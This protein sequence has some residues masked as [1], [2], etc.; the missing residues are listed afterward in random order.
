MLQLARDEPRGAAAAA[1]QGQERSALG[2]EPGELG[3]DVVNAEA[4]VVQAVAVLGQPRRER[5]TGI[6]RLDQLQVGVAEVEVGQ[7]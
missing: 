5:M 4:D 7:L 1:P 2:P 3:G 6:E